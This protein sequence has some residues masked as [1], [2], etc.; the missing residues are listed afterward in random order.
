MGNINVFA[1]LIVLFLSSQ[2]EPS[3][4]RE[5][6]IIQTAVLNRYMYSQEL[7]KASF[8]VI[9]DISYTVNKVFSLDYIFA[10]TVGYTYL[11]R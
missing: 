8:K 2:M 10:E 7:C 11:L 1:A 3:N 9:R 4:T 5:G 6:R